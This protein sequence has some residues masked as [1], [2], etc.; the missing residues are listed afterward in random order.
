MALFAYP[1]IAICLG[2]VFLKGLFGWRRVVVSEVRIQQA[3]QLRTNLRKKY[4]VGAPRSDFG[5]LT[6]LRGLSLR[7]DI[8]GMLALA[9]PGHSVDASIV[10][11]SGPSEVIGESLFYSP[12]WELFWKGYV[13]CG[14]TACG[15]NYFFDT[16][17]R[18]KDGWPQIVLLSHEESYFWV[19]RRRIEKIAKVVAADYLEFVEKFLKG[20]VEDRCLYFEDDE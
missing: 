3:S 1:F 5:F 8:P 4:S 15:D 11:L 6:L 13:V 16:K 12:G 19:P 20:S 18:D 7:T 17:R 2:V 14:S 10:T 9:G